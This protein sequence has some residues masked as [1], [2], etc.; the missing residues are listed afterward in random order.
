MPYFSFV[1]VC[2]NNWDF[3]RN[4]IDSFFDSMN[5]VHQSKGIELIIVNNGSVDE[6]ATG[7]EEYK[8][9]YKEAYDIITVSLVQ[10]LGFII[11]VNK[12]LAETKG[13]IITILN[14][15]LIFCPYW[16]DGL[17]NILEKD[18]AVGVAVPLLTNGSGEENI[19]LEFKSKEIENSF[20]KSKDT[21]N[22]YAEKIMMNNRNVIIP[23]N[24]VVGACI[25]IKREVLEL[26]GGLD[27][28]FGIGIFDDDDLSLRVNIAGYKTVIVGSSFVYHVGSATFDKDKPINKAAVISNKKKFLRK[29][30]IKCTENVEGLYVNRT[31]IIKNMPYSK[32]KHFFPLS[33]NEYNTPPENL[34][35]RNNIEKRLLLVADWTNFR[36]RWLQKLEN[37][38][39]RLDDNSSIY[40]WMPDTYFS[41]TEVKDQVE[42]ALKSIGYTDVNQ[43]V[44]YID[45]DI[46]PLDLLMFIGSFDKILTVENDFV[47]M[48][49]TDLAV[50][51]N[52]PV[53]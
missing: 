47:N 30:K 38:L 35:D 52:L 21:V 46:D 48:Q 33:Q 22:Y 51:I 17:V 26:I 37:E 2:Y 10:N 6:T 50:Q 49:I 44:D 5:P 27:F 53:Q 29:W 3:T 36:S 34:E 19:K 45:Y 14:N 11:G 43:F 7:I 41:K 39:S 31:E 24:R 12:G 9:R 15:D 4:A 13:E 8:L 32:E 18:A 42:N 25:A 20:Y 40:L 1:M 16:F 23:V 28:W